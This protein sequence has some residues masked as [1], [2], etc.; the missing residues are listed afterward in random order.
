MNSKLLILGLLTGS[1]LSSAAGTIFTGFD[2]SD[3]F[4]TGGTSDVSL[5]DGSLTVTFSGG[6]QQQMFDAPS[7][8]G[9]PAGYLFVNTGPGSASFTGTS[10]RSVTGNTDVGSVSFNIGVQELS[11]YA[12]DRANGTP[13]FRLLD[14]FGNTLLTQNPPYVIALDNLRASTVPE[15]SSALL[16]AFG[17]L[18][19]VSRRNRK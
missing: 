12:A 3:G 1:V 14:T 18:L 5:T 13:T 8:R 19:G 2:T 4:T 10:E 9:G 16:S 11:F 15:P 6:Q 7:Y 17:L